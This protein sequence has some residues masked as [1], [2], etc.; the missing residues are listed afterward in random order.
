MGRRRRRRRR[1]PQRDGVA[2]RPP[3]SSP[4]VAG[5]VAL[6]VLLA[7]R[8]VRPI[9]R[10]QVAAAAIGG[11]A[12][13]ERIE[14]DRR[15]ELG[16]LAQTFNRMAASLQELITGL[17][18]KVA[19]RT[20][21]LEVASQHKSDFLAN[22]SHEL[23][24]PLN[25]IVGFSQVLQEQLYGELNESRSSTSA[26]S[27][28]RQPPAL[29]DQRHPRPLQGGVGACRARGRPVLAPRGARAWRPDGEGEGAEGRR[30]ARA[31]ARPVGGRR[32]R[33]TSAASARS[34]STC[35]RTRSSSRRR[36]VG[37]RC[38]LSAATAR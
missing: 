29:A 14:L 19:E 16:D 7:G 3:C 31:R 6:A 35:S 25:A 22:M 12:Y 15:D 21:E 8:L 33:A 17:E 32:S 9:K 23:R 30:R 38:G 11:G 24:T 1:R 37:S 10:M 5:A 26:T 2:H 27:S 13:Q 28:P 18:W 34:S 20:R 4:F 36:A